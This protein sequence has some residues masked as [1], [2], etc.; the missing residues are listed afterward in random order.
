MEDV[1]MLMDEDC[2]KYRGI[3]ETS[4]VYSIVVSKGGLVVRSSVETTVT[5]DDS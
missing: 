5:R 1:V 4:I 2:E 3:V